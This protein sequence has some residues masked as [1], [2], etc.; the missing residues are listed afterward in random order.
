MPSQRSAALPSDYDSAIC[1]FPAK[2]EQEETETT[3]KEPPLRCLCSLLFIDFDSVNCGPGPR[4]V[5]MHLALSPNDSGTQRR[6]D[7]P[8]ISLDRN[9]APVHPIDVT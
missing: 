7:R 9:A 4:W 6:Q 1:C 5:T 8:T 3:E 2:F